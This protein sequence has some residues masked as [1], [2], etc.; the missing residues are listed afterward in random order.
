[1][2]F[3]SAPRQHSV[4][5]RCVIPAVRHCSRQPNLRLWTGRN[6]V[7]TMTPHFPQMLLIFF[8]SPSKVRSSPV[9][10]RFL[11]PPQAFELLIKSPLPWKDLVSLEMTVDLTTETFFFFADRGLTP[12]PFCALKYG[13]THRFCHKTHPQLDSLQPGILNMKVCLYQGLISF[14]VWVVQASSLLC[15]QSGCLLHPSL[16]MLHKKQKKKVFHAGV[17]PFNV[18]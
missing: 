10:G 11:C 5:D 17:G 13:C 16:L 18:K 2:R 6:L 8:F 14:L 4:E 9:E 7:T 12:S 15:S 1:M 3:F